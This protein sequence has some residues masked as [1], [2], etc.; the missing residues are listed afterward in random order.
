MLFVTTS[1]DPAGITENR[2]SSAIS[3]LSKI[4]AP[5]R[6]PRN[7]TRFESISLSLCVDVKLT[8]F[9]EIRLHFK[10]E[11]LSSQPEIAT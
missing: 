10:T 4:G 11:L 6:V 8:N 7:L 1:S 3:K 9:S 2:V 5:K